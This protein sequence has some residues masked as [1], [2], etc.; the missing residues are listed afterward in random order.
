MK[1]LSLTL[2][3]L[4]AACSSNDKHE[5]TVFT[6]APASVALGGTTQLVFN[7]TAGATLTIDQGVGDVTGKTTATVTPTAN[8]TYTLTATKGGK[9][10]TKTAAVSVTA[11]P[12]AAFRVTGPAATT[13]G[14]PV[15]FTIA[16][17]DTA[18]AVNPNYRGTVQFVS[19]DEQ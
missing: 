3:I 2:A 7:A 6:A 4:A 16:A 17:V 9:T 11:S 5:I 15:D 1:R 13:A 14:V 18:G 10:S 8:T 12:S 19:D